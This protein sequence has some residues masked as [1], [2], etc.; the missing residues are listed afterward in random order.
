M[1]NELIAAGPEAVGQAFFDRM[2]KVQD[3]GGTPLERG[4]ALA[5]FLA[6]AESDGI[7]GRLMSAP[8][9][10][11]SRC[12]QHRERSGRHPTSTRCGGSCR[13]TAGRPG[14]TGEP[15]RGDCR[16]RPDRPEASGGARPRR[17]WSPAR[18]W[19][20]LARDSWRAA[21]PALK[22]STSWESAVSRS[23]VDVV[24]VATTNDALARVARGA[25]EARQARAGRK[26][27]RAF[28]RR[29]RLAASRRPTGARRR[30]RVG[31]NHRYH[32]ALRKARELVDAGA[33][34]PL[35]FVRAR[36]GHG[37]ASATRQ[38]WRADPE[39][40]GGGEL[41]DQGVH[42]ID[43][44]RWFLGDFTSVEGV[45][46]TYFWEMPVDD[47]AFLMLRTGDRPGRVA[48]RQLHRMEEPVLVRD[49]R[50]RRQVADRRARR[51]LRRRAARPA[52]GCCRRWGR[53]RRRAGSF[54]APTIRG[55]SSSTSSSKT[56]GWSVQPAAGTRRRARGALRR[57]GDLP[58][59][60]I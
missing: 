28:G 14:A 55:T 1:M 24:I 31:F 48:A 6:S 59:L 42:L 11:G 7:T 38:E 49:L 50:P 8:G 3:E 53:R 43:L 47:N 5:V 30:V 32:P 60:G 2:R 29:D 33:L 37:G 16:L 20:W 17:S 40:S 58:A 13:G 39:I 44:A 10:R 9:I 54:P 21:C 36:Y 26:A 27:G 4:A 25:L 57:R 51:Q 52:T 34:G 41:I 18:T 46:T 23:D 12:Q 22:R 35:M 15:R 19:T 56:S 45:A